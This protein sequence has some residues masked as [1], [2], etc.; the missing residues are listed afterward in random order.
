MISPLDVRDPINQGDLQVGHAA[1]KGHRLIQDKRRWHDGCEAQ[2]I[3]GVRNF[4]IQTGQDEK[5]GIELAAAVQ[6][7]LA[8]GALIRSSTGSGSCAGATPR[9][10][11]RS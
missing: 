11:R 7:R 1:Q 3:E 9:A 8:F 2:A 4:R 10:C 6:Q 5:A